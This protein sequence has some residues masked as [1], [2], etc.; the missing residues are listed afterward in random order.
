MAHKKMDKRNWDLEPQKF[1]AAQFL[2]YAASTT[3]GEKLL[4][5]SLE[6]RSLNSEGLTIDNH[7]R[8]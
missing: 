1:S 7:Q 2:T 6:V 5:A 4:R 3:G 8:R